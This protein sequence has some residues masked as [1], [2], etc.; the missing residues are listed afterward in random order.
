MR[1][2]PSNQLSYHS[3]LLYEGKKKETGPCHGESIGVSVNKTKP[4]GKKVSNLQAAR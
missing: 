1:P 3:K 2:C 4:N